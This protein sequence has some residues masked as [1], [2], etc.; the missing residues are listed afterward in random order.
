VKT[1][2]DKNDE[3]PLIQ[4]RLAETIMTLPG[5]TLEEEFRRRNTAIDTVAAYCHF[6]E[7]GA[8]TCPRARPSTQKVSPT[9]S[10]ETNPQLAAA[11]V[12]NQALNNAMLLVF[13]EKRTTICFLCLGEENLRL[14]KRIKKFASPGD[15]TKHFKRKHLAHIKEGD[16]P[17]CKVCKIGLRH[18]QHLQN[19][20]LCIHG[21]VS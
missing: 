12:E 17:K 4:K 16:R 9:L 20:A 18:K 13:T 6:Q 10:K 11:E 15:L 14:K 8:V 2:L 21:T 7:G 5:T 3:M 1:T 19:H